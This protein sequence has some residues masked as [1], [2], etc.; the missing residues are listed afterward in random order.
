ME[1]ADDEAV[2]FVCAD[3]PA[4]VRPFR[5]DYN[6]ELLFGNKK[7]KA[8]SLNPIERR[9]NGLGSSAF[10]GIIGMIS[11]LGMIKFVRKTS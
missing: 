11:T 5:G 3:L 9:L 1:K 2:G 7:E 6:L 10:F 4:R 8:L